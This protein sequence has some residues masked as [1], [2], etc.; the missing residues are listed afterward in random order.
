MEYNVYCDETNHLKINNGEYMA[1]GAIYLPKSRVKK[2]N[3]YLQDLKSK[4]GLTETQELKWNL[5]KNSSVNLYLDIINYFF[6]GEDDIRFR[7]I[8][9]KKELID[10]ETYNQTED[11]FYYKMCYTMLR[12]L[13]YPADS[14]NIYPDIKDNNSYYRHQQVLDYLRIKTK[15]TNNK[16]IK[17]IQPIKSS[18][19]P[20]MQLADIFIG[21]LVYY[22]NYPENKNKNKAKVLS[23]I[24]NNV[25]I[26]NT[27]PYNNTKFNLLY[28]RSKNDIEN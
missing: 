28:W 1:F 18:D 2:I 22:N 3:K 13:I 15:D 4:Y 23:E 16:T 20:L 17:K 25:K 26:D 10:N 6:N 5:I 11:D 14:Y 21:A 24:I 8:L 19:A 27:T 9:I 7:A 12:Y